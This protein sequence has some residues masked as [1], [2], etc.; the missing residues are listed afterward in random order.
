MIQRAD[1]RTLIPAL[2]L[3]S[4]PVIAEDAVDVVDEPQPAAEEDTLLDLGEFGDGGTLSDDELNAERAR[5]KIE[6]DHI[7]LNDQTQDGDVADNVAIG[8]TNGDNLINGSAFSDA[9]GFMSTVQNS[10]NNVLIQNSTIINVAVET[11]SN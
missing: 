10:G 7:S 8:N 6:V 3:L 11:P 4:M 9:S 1:R 5:E 2:L